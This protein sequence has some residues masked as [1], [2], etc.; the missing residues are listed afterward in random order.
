MGVNG[1]GLPKIKGMIKYLR[2]CVATGFQWLIDKPLAWLSG[3]V[4]LFGIPGVLAW[5]NWAEILPAVGVMFLILLWVAQSVGAYRLHKDL[6]AR[7]PITSGSR[8][9]VG[10]NSVSNIGPGG[11]GIFIGHQDNRP[12]PAGPATPGPSAEP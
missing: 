10:A 3:I 12:N 8:V 11:H 4:G 5:A 2:L 1:R 9:I 7:P 6:E